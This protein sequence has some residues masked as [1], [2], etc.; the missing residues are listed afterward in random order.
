MSARQDNSNAKV[1]RIR[2]SDISSDIDSTSLRGLNVERSLKGTSVIQLGAEQSVISSSRHDND[3]YFN[4]EPGD[5]SVL[6]ELQDYE[7]N[8]AAPQTLTKNL[9]RDQ[10]ADFLNLNKHPERVLPVWR[11]PL[12][13]H[14][15]GITSDTNE[16]QA[17]SSA[18][19]K[20]S[21]L[22]DIEISHAHKPD[23]DTNVVVLLINGKEQLCLDSK[24]RQA[25]KTINIDPKSIYERIEQNLMYDQ[26]ATEY[27]FLRYSEAGASFFLYVIDIAWLDRLEKNDQE[28]TDI[29]E[30]QLHNAAFRMF[31]LQESVADRI[32]YSH[33]NH[34][35]FW[36][37]MRDYAPID[38]SFMR[39]LYGKKMRQPRTKQQAAKCLAYYMW[40]EISSMKTEEIPKKWLMV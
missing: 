24:Y 29:F 15:V 23:K 2:N 21:L 6:D 31:S 20:M 7:I 4:R 5:F 40:K 35:Y 27:R 9:V 36:K 30:A 3:R 25:L 17:Y 37:R 28:K 33:M 1:I 38:K 39:V 16:A 34:K 13:I 10:V 22:S 18:L 12:K 14:T 32:K 8:P 26:Q 11:K 19:N